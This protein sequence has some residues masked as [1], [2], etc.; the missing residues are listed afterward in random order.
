MA[1]QNQQFSPSIPQ[2][3]LSDSVIWQ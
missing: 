1:Q 3:V 2:Q